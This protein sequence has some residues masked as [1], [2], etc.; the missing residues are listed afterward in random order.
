MESRRESKKTR[1]SL[2]RDAM[3]DSEEET[4]QLDSI[5]QNNG[6]LVVPTHYDG[7]L[8]TDFRSTLA[9]CLG[10]FTFTLQCISENRGN[11]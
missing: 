11:L 1:N 5:D 8:V 3:V 7:D 6:A 10:F 4:A 2:L 9:Q